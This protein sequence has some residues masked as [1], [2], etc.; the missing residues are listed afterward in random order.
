M[1]YSAKPQSIIPPQYLKALEKLNRLLSSEPNQ[2]PTLPPIQ[3]SSRTKK[4]QIN[5]S[6]QRFIGFFIAYTFMVLPFN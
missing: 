1:L 4:N 5:Q 6:E 3:G 2:R